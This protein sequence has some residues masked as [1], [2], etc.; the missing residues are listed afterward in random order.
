MVSPTQVFSLVSLAPLSVTWN[1]PISNA[2]GSITYCHTFM[3]VLWHYLGVDD[4]IL[5]LYAHDSALAASVKLEQQLPIKGD[6]AIWEYDG[7]VFSL[8]LSVEG[9]ET[10]DTVDRSVR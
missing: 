2:A 8:A 9:T 4:F 3:P 7:L 5:S 10:C 6:Q 1:L